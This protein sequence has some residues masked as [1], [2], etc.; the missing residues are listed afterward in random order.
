MKRMM[1]LLILSTLPEIAGAQSIRIVAPFTRA[2]YASYELTRQYWIVLPQGESRPTATGAPSIS[3]LNEYGQRW[4][5]VSRT[6]PIQDPEPTVEDTLMPQYESYR[7]PDPSMGPTVLRNPNYTV[8]HVYR[9][10]VVTSYNSEE[11]QTDSSPWEIR[12]NHLVRFGDAAC[13]FLPKGTLFR[14]PDAP[15]PF[16]TVVFRVED[17]TAPKFA[18][19]ID[20]WLLHVRDA[21]NWGRKRLTVE[22]LGPPRG[23][24]PR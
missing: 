10:I 19:R 16:N 23:E 14:L 2:P 15:K 9:N 18:D 4:Q 17:E 5:T 1:W 24:A 12:K 3:Q 7:Y 8:R 20:L 21:E 22:V 13:N 11:R 6:A